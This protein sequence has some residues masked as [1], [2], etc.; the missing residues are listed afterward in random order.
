MDFYELAEGEPIVVGSKAR[1]GGEPVTG[2]HIIEDVTYIFEN[3]EV[4][5]I[6]EPTDGESEDVMNLKA[7]NEALKAELESFKNTIEEQK[8]EIQNYVNFKNKVMNFIPDAP[9]VEKSEPKEEPKN[10]IRK[11]NFK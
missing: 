1:A 6:V 7:E 9:I 2:E 10:Q 11:F 4:A 3:G 8:N 5:T